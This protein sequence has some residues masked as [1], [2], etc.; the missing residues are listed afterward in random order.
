MSVADL[1]ACPQC[2][3][4]LQWIGSQQALWFRWLEVPDP[5][6]R[7]AV[8]ESRAHRSAV[9]RLDGAVQERARVA[10]IAAQAKGSWREADT[11]EDFSAARAE[12][13]TR[14]AWLSWV[15]LLESGR[16]LAVMPAEV[17]VPRFPASTTHR[18]ARG[19]LCSQARGA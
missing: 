18:A 11:G 5:I 14:E 7:M 8:S 12:V 16:P 9:T 13:V 15:E 4:P 1:A 3:Q 10:H 6:P 19:Q 17:I 2:G